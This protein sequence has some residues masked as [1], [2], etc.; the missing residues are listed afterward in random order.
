VFC[1]EYKIIDK[2]QK[3]SNINQYLSILEFDSMADHT[4]WIDQVKKDVEKRG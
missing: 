4:Q 2:V 1:S 3:Y